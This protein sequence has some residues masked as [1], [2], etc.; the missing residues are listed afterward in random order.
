MA[1]MDA[2]PPTTAQ[3]TVPAGAAP[4]TPTP[5]LAVQHAIHTPTRAASRRRKAEGDGMEISMWSPGMEQRMA[6]PEATYVSLF[7]DDSQFVM[8]SATMP[9]AEKDVYNEFQKFRTRLLQ[10]FRC[11]H[12]RLASLHHQADKPAVPSF[13]ANLEDTKRDLEKLKADMGVPMNFKPAIDALVPELIKKEVDQ[14]RL[15][16]AEPGN[17]QPVVDKLV[18]PLLDAK[19]GQ[20]E[21]AMLKLNEI[22]TWREGLMA[23]NFNIAEGEFQQLKTRLSETETSISMVRASIGGQSGDGDR[24]LAE[25]IARVDNLDSTIAS[26]EVGYKIF[27]T[28]TINEMKS[29]FAKPPQPPGMPTGAS[30][31]HGPDCEVRPG[32]CHHVATLMTQM[33]DASV[34]LERHKNLI[35]T[36]EKHVA[37]IRSEISAWN[38]TKACTQPPFDPA[39]DT[40][41]QSRGMGQ[42]TSGTAGPTT[43]GYSQGPQAQR[44]HS[45]DA[46]PLGTLGPMGNVSSMKLFLDT[47][48]LDSKYQY[49]GS[50]DSGPSWREKVRGYFISK[51]PVLHALL[52]WAE[53]HDQKTISLD[54][55]MAAVGTR[56]TRDDMELLSIQVWGF[57]RT[58]VTATAE[59]VHSS[60]EA[61]N[62]FEAWRRLVRHIDWGSAIYLEEMRTAVRHITLKPIKR[63]EDITVGVLD[64]EKILKKYSEAG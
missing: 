14:L 18:G 32:H 55:V 44:I 15:D 33:Q 41:A 50:K 1:A 27:I 46:V 2:N 61:M 29:T 54:M 13:V 21:N 25:L 8:P 48:A 10:E 11:V 39:W 52:P 40:W 26:T 28:D 17:F 35:E 60:G 45:N 63:L 23:S 19:M 49:N 38:S 43:S 37:E 20:I 31:S 57:L 53:A 30:S 6:D 12:T 34:A 64:F 3:T 7:L 62:G 24:T 59:T 51:S 22:T 16:M 58:C 56:V 9:Q 42:G 5:T 36:M 47:I 4:S